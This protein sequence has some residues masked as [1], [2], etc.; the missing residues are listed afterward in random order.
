MMPILDYGRSPAA[1][2]VSTQTI[3]RMIALLDDFHVGAAIAA[4]VSLGQ[5][6]RRQAMPVL[7]RMIRSTPT[8]EMI[9]ALASIAD[10]YCLVELGRL[11]ERQPVLRDAVC[12]AL[13]GLDH[14]RAV[15][16]LRRLERGR[17]DSQS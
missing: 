12:E 5:M 14:P 16:V 4:A 1:A 6:G 8:A 7:L 3:P 11:A 2:P 15:T 10:D 9:H 13:E 17:V